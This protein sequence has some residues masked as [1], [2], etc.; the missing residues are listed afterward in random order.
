[1]TIRT[2]LTLWYA[3]IFSASLLLI[4]SAMYYELVVEQRTKIAA[5]ENIGVDDDAGLDITQIILIYGGTA[6]AVGLLGGWWLTR[7]AFVPVARLTDAVESIS[8]KNLGEKIPRTGNGDE[9]DRLT[10]VFNAID[11]KSVV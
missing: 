4:G 2:R 9:L 10:E 7:R 5:H 6:V 1:M 11:R 3:V 8:E